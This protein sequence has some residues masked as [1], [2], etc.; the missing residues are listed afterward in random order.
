MT[1]KNLRLT[2]GSLKK[3]ISEVM[4]EDAGPP[5]GSVGDPI[6]KKKKGKSDKDPTDQRKVIDAVRVAISDAVTDDVRKKVH[7]H[8]Q[9]TGVIKYQD[10]EIISEPPKTLIRLKGI[11]GRNGEDMIYLVNVTKIV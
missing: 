10:I 7:H 3:I 1:D 8:L 11:N 5:P 2:L 4:Q 9:S 6:G